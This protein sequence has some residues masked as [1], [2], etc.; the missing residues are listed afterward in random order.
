MPE[1][2]T[3]KLD[4][5]LASIIEIAKIPSAAGRKSAVALA[6]KTQTKGFKRINS[7]RCRA[8]SLLRNLAKFII[9][10]PSKIIPLVDSKRIVIN[11][12]SFGKRVATNDAKIGNPIVFA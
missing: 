10:I 8:S 1:Q 5:S 3:V 9:P 7:N 12:S 4:V 2:I 11:I 6:E